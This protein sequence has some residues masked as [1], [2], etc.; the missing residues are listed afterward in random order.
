MALSESIIVELKTKKHKCFITCLY[1]SPSQSSDEFSNFCDDLEQTLS[2]LNNEAP[3]C[4]IVL[5][6]FNARNKKWLTTDNNSGPGI[7]LEKLF[8]STGFAQ[9]IKDPTNLEPNKRETLID[10]I[11]V[12]QI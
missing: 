5:G 3:L 11:F 8:S 2:S 1:R 9:L 12:N 6:D 4:S 7:E 10:L